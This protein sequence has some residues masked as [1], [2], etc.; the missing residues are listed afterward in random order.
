MPKYEFASC[1][2]VLTCPALLLYSFDKDNF[3]ETYIPP[4]VF[5]MTL[6]IICVIVICIEYQAGINLT[7][8]KNHG[9]SK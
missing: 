2:A 7:S 9:A 5:G 4:L 8:S 6:L 3:S 1:I